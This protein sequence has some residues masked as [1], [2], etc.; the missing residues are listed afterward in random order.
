M[1][2]F[3]NNLGPV[4]D[5]IL[6]VLAALAI[7]ILGYIVARVVASVVRSLLRRTGSR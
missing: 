1:Q 2:D 6:T 7:L 3:F 4:G 5:T